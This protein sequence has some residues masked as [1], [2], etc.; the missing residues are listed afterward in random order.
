VVGKGEKDIFEDTDFEVDALG[1]GDADD[2]TM[3]LE[4]NSDFDI[5]EADSA[6]EVFAMDEDDVDDNASTAMAPAMLEEEEEDEFETDVDAEPAAAI[7]SG[8]QG[9]VIP[10]SRDNVEWGGLWVGLLGVGSVLTL[11]AAFVAVDLIRNLYDFRG[12]GP[13]SGIIQALAGLFPK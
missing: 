11:L 3:Q 1:S 4:A 7:S 13:A 10:T 2:R 8:S 5:D 6:S 9:T 12:G